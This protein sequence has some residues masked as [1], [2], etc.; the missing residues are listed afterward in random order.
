MIHES[1]RVTDESR[2]FWES[3]AYGRLRLPYCDRC[4]RWVWF[5]RS[6][7]PGCGSRVEWRPTA[8]L[9]TLTSYTVERRATVQRWRDVVPYVIAI[10]TLDEG[11]ALMSNV[12]GSPPSELTIGARL[13]VRFEPT[14]NPELAVP[15]FE[16]D[17]PK[18][19]TGVSNLSGVSDD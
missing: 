15:V 4:D 8:G 9:G 11:V 17:P 14:D 5:P 16:I 3:A 1:P 13:R 10:V 12:V 2:P 18:S 6:T 7:C 19:V